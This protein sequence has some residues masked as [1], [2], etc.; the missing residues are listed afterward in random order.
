MNNYQTILGSSKIEREKSKSTS[1]KKHNTKTYESS[2]IVDHKLLLQQ[3]GN[4]YN[5]IIKLFLLFN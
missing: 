3:V 4:R 2:S 1:P 5:F